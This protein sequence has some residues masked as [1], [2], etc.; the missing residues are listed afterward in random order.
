M[1]Q[2]DLSHAH[3]TNYAASSYHT[4]SLAS[5]Y[6]SPVPVYSNLA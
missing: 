4:Y 2:K 5:R 1:K 3:V 6:E